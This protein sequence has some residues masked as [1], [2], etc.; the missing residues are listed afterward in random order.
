MAVTSIWRDIPGWEGRYQ[1]SALG[2]IRSMPKGG[3]PGVILRERYIARTRSMVKDAR[4][5]LCR[6]G[7]METVRVGTLVARAWCPGYAPGLQVNHKDGNP[8]NNK[9]SNLE[10]VTG[11]QNN[12]HA[13]MA[14]LILAIPVV[15]ARNGERACFTHPAQRQAGRSAMRT[16]ISTGC[17]IRAR[18]K[19]LIKTKTSMR[20]YSWEVRKQRE[21]LFKRDQRPVERD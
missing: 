4:V 8:L 18:G 5:N 10:W 12:A 13:I 11:A 3:K 1:A 7:A 14:G 20:S 2:H 21:G 6:D 15:L 17:S 9:A 19:R 16:V